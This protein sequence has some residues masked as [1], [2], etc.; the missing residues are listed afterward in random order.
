MALPVPP[1]QLTYDDYAALPDDGKRYEL[2]DGVLYVVPSPSYWHQ[3]LIG[4]LHAK[5]FNFLEAHPLGEV[6]VSP[7]DVVLTPVRAW[8]PDLLY[9]SKERLEI[10]KKNNALGAPD[11]VVEVLSSNASRDLGLKK[12][13]YQE[14]GVKEYWVVW[15]D[16]PRI[17]VFK[18]GAD[19]TF[20]DPRL[21]ESGKTLTSEMLPGF[22][23][24]MDALYQGLE[25]PD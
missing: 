13:A 7:F 8:Q 11:M 14:A 2:I 10:I 4:R 22:E 6:V 9:I 3:K 12:R 1:R 20:G 19:G 17:E 5:L 16:V 23:L 18:L 25:M 21:F 24:T 15:Q